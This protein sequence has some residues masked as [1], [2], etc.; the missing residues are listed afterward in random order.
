MRSKLLFGLAIVAMLGLT[1]CG[2]NPPNTMRGQPAEENPPK[3]IAAVA[4]VPAS[5]FTS[6]YKVVIYPGSEEKF[7]PKP[8]LTLKEF[9]IL[10]QFDWYCAKQASEMEGELQEML[11][12]GATYG[13]F[14]GVFGALGYKLGFGS[15]INPGDYLIAI[16]LTAFGGGLGSGKITFETAMAVLQGY[17]VTGMVYKADQ[18]EGKLSRLWI[19]PL[20][21]GGARVPAVSN[22]PA[23]T[24]SDTRGRRIAPLPR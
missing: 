23:P 4:E 17:C 19:V 11:K 12:Q 20:Y 5:Q 15:L 14:Q 16:G 10:S 22:R 9:N 21:T 18:L 3:A 8:S 13:G 1:A 2:T 24:Y 6:R 7:N